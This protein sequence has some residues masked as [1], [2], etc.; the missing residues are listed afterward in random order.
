MQELLQHGMLRLI[1]RSQQDPDAAASA[2]VAE[3]VQPLTQRV[4]PAAILA[5]TELRAAHAAG[6]LKEC[7]TNIRGHPG[8]GCALADSDHL[9]H[10]QTETCSH[11]NDTV[12]CVSNSRTWCCVQEGVV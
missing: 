7:L 12:P 1:Q 10:S 2:G 11:M 6:V 3:L 4:L 9:H 8:G 5:E